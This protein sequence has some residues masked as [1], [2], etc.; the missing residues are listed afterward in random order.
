MPGTTNVPTSLNTTME[1]ADDT[2][3]DK[4]D[5]KLTPDQFQIDDDKFEWSSRA[6]ILKESLDQLVE[7]LRIVDKKYQQLTRWD[8]ELQNQKFKMES[9]RTKIQ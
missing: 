1:P 5:K 2:D 6:K 8:S 9:R 3:K 7:A 4:L